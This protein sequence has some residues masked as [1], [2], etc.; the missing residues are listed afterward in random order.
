V[1]RCREPSL[2]LAHHRAREPR[3]TQLQEV[4]EDDAEDW[5][6]LRSLAAERRRFGYRRLREMARRKRRRRQVL[7]SYAN[8]YYNASRTH[9]SLDKDA[10]VSRAVQRV[11]RIVSHA[12]ELRRWGYAARGLEPGSQRAFSR[13]PME[14][15][16][17]DCKSCR[18]RLR[19]G[20]MTAASAAKTSRTSSR[21]IERPEQSRPIRTSV[22]LSKRVLSSRL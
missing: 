8:N 2:V 16:R 14:L 6:L 11:G 4:F 17:R 5:E 21:C 12:L 18:A 3:L 20:R 13:G 19:L 22:A 1:T 9:C 7:K 10:P 15:H